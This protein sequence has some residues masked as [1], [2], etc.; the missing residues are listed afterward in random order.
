[1]LQGQV[2]V[3]LVR[4]VD[5]AGT[6]DEARDALARELARIAA[7]RHAG[8]CS[9]EPHLGEQRARELGVEFGKD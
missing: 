9:V 3:W 1:M 7:E 4:L 5:A 6:D 2:F 8:E